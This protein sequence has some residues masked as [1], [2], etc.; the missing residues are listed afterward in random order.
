MKAG[1]L[2][3][4]I[5]GDWGTTHFRLRFDD[6]EFKSDDG[7]ARLAAAGP[8]RPAA[9]RTALDRGLRELGAPVDLPVVISGMAS[10]TI[11]W[12]ELPY[13]RTPFACDGSNVV[14][15][16][17]DGRVILVSG[18]R[19]DRE[20]LRGEETE[21]LGLVAHLGER[22]PAAATLVLP[23]THSK[24]L[25]VRN[26]AIVDFRTFMTGELFDLLARQSV[27][28][29]STDLGAALD[30]EG[31]VAGVRE[32]RVRPLSNALFQVR[33]RQVLDRCPPASNTAFLSGLLIGAELASL[34]DSSEA[35][36]S[37]AGRTLADAYQ[38]AAETLGLGPRWHRIDSDR[39]AVLGQSVILQ[40]ISASR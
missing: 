23:G 31:F 13:A 33:T 20:I 38:I 3:R 15:E 39:L 6:R 10:S 14:H 18:L 32:A 40:R 21:A 16:C 2:A 35:I 36:F 7:T 24:H 5:S 29:H 27:L 1:N 12:R 19:T 26:G 28:R 30:R 34:A 17:I 4:F 9:F 8:D 37:A 22:I 25:I 11:G